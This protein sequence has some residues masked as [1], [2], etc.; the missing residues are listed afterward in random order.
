LISISI[1]QIQ[2]LEQQ[3]KE[4]KESKEVAVGKNKKIAGS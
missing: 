4:L 2:E 1:A 3:L